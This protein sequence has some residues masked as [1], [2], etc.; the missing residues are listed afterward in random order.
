M[1]CKVSLQKSQPFVIYNIYS[2][3]SRDVAFA[4]LIKLFTQLYSDL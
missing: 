1:G 3:S 4:E 2:D